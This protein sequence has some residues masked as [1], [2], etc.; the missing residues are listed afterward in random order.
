MP[1]LEAQERQDVR[2]RK[3]TSPK[4]PQRTKQQEPSETARTLTMWSVC[5]IV[6]SVCY[7]C[8]ELSI[9]APRGE[10]NTTIDFVMVS[11]PLDGH[12]AL[13]TQINE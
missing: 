3:A 9:H 8:L 5:L 4:E 13:H 10:V 11:F 12:K 6:T 1:Q 2:E 7:V